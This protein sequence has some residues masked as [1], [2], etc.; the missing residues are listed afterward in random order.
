MR[1]FL[2]ITLFC[3]CLLGCETPSHSNAENTRVVQPEI[4]V[5]VAA[6]AQYALEEIIEQFEKKHAISVKT[7]MG[8]SGQLTTQ[9]QNGAPL[10]VLISADTQYPEYLQKQ[11]FAWKAPRVYAQGIL[12]LWSMSVQDLSD[13]EKLLTSSQ[14]KKI[15]LAQPELAPYGR[16]ARD[17]LEQKQLWNTVSN[18]LIYG[19]SIAQVNQYII[20]ET[21]EMGF[22]AKSTLLI[23]H[24]EQ[25]GYYQEFKGQSTEQKAVLLKYAQEHE[26]DASQT[27]YEFLFSEEARKIFQKFGYE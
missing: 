21:V 13:W 8:S 14:I 25:K 16:L 12:V 20:T 3:L 26:P 10:M 27:F 24:L 19:Q 17:F 23:P 5:A 6:N 7:V 9:I 15:A 2:M 22:T 18:K 1:F 4:T 11:G